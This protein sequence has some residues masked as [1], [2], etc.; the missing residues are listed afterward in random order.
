MLLTF[1]LIA[2]INNN[3]NNN[4]NNNN[5]NNINAIDQNSQNTV[6]NTNA[7]NQISVTVLPIP[8][9]RSF[10]KLRSA[11][12]LYQGTKN[13]VDES[14]AAL[15]FTHIVSVY[16]KLDSANHNCN[17]YEICTG[18]KDIFQLFQLDN[19]VSFDLLKIGRNPNLAQIS[20]KRLFPN[21][22]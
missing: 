13:K 9:K 14:V 3:L 22:S 2:N 20:C 10:R 18:V 7:A 6:T 12:C 15:L 19:I 11:E 4:N 8:G 5:D 21:C 17:S 1:N 16:S